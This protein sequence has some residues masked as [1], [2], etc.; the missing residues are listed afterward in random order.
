[1]K[2]IQQWKLREGEKYVDREIGSIVLDASD[3]QLLYHDGY[4]GN[5]FLRTSDKTVWE[6]VYGWENGERFVTTVKLSGTTFYDRQITY[7][8]TILPFDGNRLRI[9]FGYLESSVR[10]ALKNE[11]YKVLQENDTGY[12]FI[13]TMQ[14][15][16]T[17]FLDLNR[18]NI[19]FGRDKSILSPIGIM[20]LLQEKGV[21]KNKFLCIYYMCDDFTITLEHTRT[22]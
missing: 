11:G 12:F 7:V 17:C 20:A 9:R 6:E 8:S 5:I 21:L 14:D 1:M 3:L 18:L 22:I 16:D 10:K 15:D 19:P 2:R 13:E 4:A